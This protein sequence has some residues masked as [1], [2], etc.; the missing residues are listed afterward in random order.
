MSPERCKLLAGTDADADDPVR[1]DDDVVELEAHYVDSRGRKGK[2]KQTLD[3]LPS[4]GVVTE[5]GS[6]KWQPS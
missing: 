1:E 2:K 4:W 6:R 5:G 3:A